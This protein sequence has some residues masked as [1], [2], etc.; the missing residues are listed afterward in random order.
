MCVRACM[1]VHAVCLGRGGGD[2]SDVFLGKKNLAK[3]IHEEERE[4]VLQEVRK[5]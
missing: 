4:D 3:D 1:C 5:S 2:K